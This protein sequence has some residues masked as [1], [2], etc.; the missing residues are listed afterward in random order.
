MLVKFYGESTNGIVDKL[1]PVHTNS[2]GAP[3]SQMCS[4]TS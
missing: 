1:V 4:P 3:W 2:L